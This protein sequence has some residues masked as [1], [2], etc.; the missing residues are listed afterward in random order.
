MAFVA[1]MKKRTTLLLLGLTLATGGVLLATGEVPM[2]SSEGVR[3]KLHTPQ[4]PTGSGR[5][6][7]PINARIVCQGD[8]NTRGAGGNTLLGPKADVKPFCRWL[9]EALGGSVAITIRAIGGQTAGEGLAQWQDAGS[10]DF[11]I[12]MYGTNDA[13]PRGWLSGDRVPPANYAKALTAMIQQ[14]RAQGAEVLVL[15]P[16]PA[17]ATGIERR[18]APYRAAAR[19]AAV[20]GGAAFLDPVEAFPQ[21]AVVLT[22]DALHLSANGQKLLGQWLAARIVAAGQGV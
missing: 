18:V 5:F 10:G 11:V 14:H 21:D 3:A 22:S 16:L 20:A 1:Q 19:A 8:S 9:G 17:G 6:T 13:A 15:A 4:P 2:F 12:V 7:V